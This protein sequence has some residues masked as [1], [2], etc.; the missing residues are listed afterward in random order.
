MM[1]PD[2]SRQESSS[3]QCI[4]VVARWVLVEI[5]SFPCKVKQLDWLVGIACSPPQLVP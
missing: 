1:R 3:C 4:D 2:C 5:V